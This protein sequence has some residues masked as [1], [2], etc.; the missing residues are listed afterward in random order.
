M[1]LKTESKLDFCAV[2]SFWLIR[3]LPMERFILFSIH[4]LSMV[5][6]Y[7]L[8]VL[9]K[10]KMPFSKFLIFERMSNKG[11]SRHVAFSRSYIIFVLTSGIF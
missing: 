4:L 3:N 6:N 9:M 10:K 7:N 2:R 8:S 5:N 1:N 11:K